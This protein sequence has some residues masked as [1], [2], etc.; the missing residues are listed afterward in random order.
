MPEPSVQVRDPNNNKEAPVGNTN[1]KDEINLSSDIKV[2]PKA[3]APSFEP[4]VKAKNKPGPK[5]K[6]KPEPTPKAS[7]EEHRIEGDT[8]PV[9][10][11]AAS[12]GRIVRYET[13]AS[14]VRPAIITRV[15]DASV[16]LTVFNSEGAVPVPGVSYSEENLPGTY[17]WPEMN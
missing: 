2:E 8:E 14:T 13:A 1:P 6:D 15:N 12:I 4:E 11:P 16:D 9:S 10:G 7:G 3:E 5:P 17:H